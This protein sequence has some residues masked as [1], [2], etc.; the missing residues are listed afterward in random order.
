MNC[1]FVA[2][3][4]FN[5]VRE[6]LLDVV[7]DESSALPPLGLLMVA[8]Y[9]ES[10]DAVT[11]V[12]VLDCQ[13]ERLSWRE[14]GE[15]IRSERPDVV[16][17]QAMT[18]TLIDANKVAQL[19]KELLPRAV[20]I[21]GGP[22]PTLYPAE[23]V[24]SPYVDYVVFGEGEFA[25]RDLLTALSKGDSPDGIRGVVTKNT[26][27]ADLSLD[28]IENL[29]DLLPPARH[30]I[31]NSLYSSSL[32]S[33]EAITT[34]MSSRGC[35]GRC[36]FCDRPQMGKVFRKRSA[37]GVFLEMKECVERWGIKE[38]TFYD[39][40]FT[41]DKQRV[42]D[43]CAMLVEAKLDV[44]WDIRARIDTMTS[45]MIRA[46]ASAG[47]VR[48][49][50]GVETGDERL[51][52]LIKKNLDLSRVKEV[53]LE[54]KKAGIETLGYFML[55]LPSET[56]AEME[57]TIRLMCSLPFDFAHIAVFTPY[58][59]TRAY[60]EALANGLYSEDFWKAFAENPQAGF[61]PPSWEENFTSAQ[62][63][64]IMR[65][66]YRRFYFRPSYLLKR[67]LKV[68]SFHEFRKKARIGLEL[69]IDT[70]I[71]YKKKHTAT[72]RIL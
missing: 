43:L 41:I 38:I 71:P 22:H 49:H 47:C 13:A 56:P 57:K 5:I 63:H 70:C 7:E 9:A 61:V 25:T 72:S 12:S 30:L 44:R 29:D 45:E 23:T 11:R 39:D 65:K 64:G 52:K 31:N 15:R 28:Y 34:M 55:G 21:M 16:G 1:L 14:I 46:L 32:A 35:P 50:Y 53:V 59:G 40:T 8:A 26:D 69:F 60:R 27:V 6:S 67:L 54:T 62:L 17:I 18:F 42:L 36:I 58:P 20:V 48:I 24:R 3:P 51:Q 37:H 68:R 2:P 33:T 10:V 19:V 66:A 4:A